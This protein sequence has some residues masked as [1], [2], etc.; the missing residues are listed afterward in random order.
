MNVD[1]PLIADRS[2]KVH[3][4]PNKYEDIMDQPWSTLDLHQ[5]AHD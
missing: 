5:G 1:S 4:F 2:I 3:I